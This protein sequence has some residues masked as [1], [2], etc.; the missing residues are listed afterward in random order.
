MLL[1]VPLASPVLH[2]VNVAA[3][4]VVSDRPVNVATPL[5]VEAV[6]VPLA[7]LVGVPLTIAVMMRLAELL[8]T[9]LPY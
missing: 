5:T 7:K 1:L 3:P 8:V 9:V 4:A 6:V 2:T